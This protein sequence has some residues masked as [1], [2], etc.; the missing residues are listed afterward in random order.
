MR[1]KRTIL[2]ALVLGGTCLGA[3]LGL[4][5]PGDPAIADVPITPTEAPTDA[6]S[7]PVT[8][9]ADEPV[10][11]TTTNSPTSAPTNPSAPEPDQ[12]ITSV[13]ST[14]VTLPPGA[15]MLQVDFPCHEDE[16]LGYHPRF[17][18]DHVGCIHVGEFP[19]PN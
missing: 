8:V 10:T 13:P 14:T 11:S 17:G 12:S 16:V 1:L 18:P 4:G 19:L 2:S 3:T 5:G 15:I 6:P 9:P 7:E